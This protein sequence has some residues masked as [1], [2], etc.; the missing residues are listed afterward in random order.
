MWPELS[1]EA[2][3]NAFM[4]LNMYLALRA[5]TVFHDGGDCA[6][7]MGVIDMVAPTVEVWQAEYD[8]PDIWADFELLLALR[9][10]VAASC[11][12]VRPIEPRDRTDGPSCFYI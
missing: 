9:A 6:R 7:A 8:N 5:A 4:M 3:G 11:T 1:D 12:S 2:R 10:N